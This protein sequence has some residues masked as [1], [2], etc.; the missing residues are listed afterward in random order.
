MLKQAK[1]S[2]IGQ[3]LF[4]LQ[5][6]FLVLNSSLG[7]HESVGLGE[8]CWKTFPL[9]PAKW[10]PEEMRNGDGVGGKE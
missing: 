3:E 9:S 5:H 10:F 2:I 7:V 4:T 6:G 8:V 1:Q